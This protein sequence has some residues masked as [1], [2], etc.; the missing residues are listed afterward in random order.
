[1]LSKFRDPLHINKFS[2]S[3]SLKIFCFLLLLRQKPRILNKACKSDLYPILFL[4]HVHDGCFESISGTGLLS[5]LQIHS[6]RVFTR[7]FSPLFTR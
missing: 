1:M 6:L 4:P 7:V 2:C 3:H 5:A